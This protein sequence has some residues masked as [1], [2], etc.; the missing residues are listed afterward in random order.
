MTAGKITTDVPR[1]RDALHVAENRQLWRRV[2][3]LA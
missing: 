1:L 2:S 3:L